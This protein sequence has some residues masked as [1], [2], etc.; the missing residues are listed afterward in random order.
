MK[1]C[2]WRSRLAPDELCSA[3]SRKTAGLIFSR[4]LAMSLVTF[5]MHQ[6]E[7]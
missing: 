4:S 7:S 6:M 1:A 5:A 3:I 2:G